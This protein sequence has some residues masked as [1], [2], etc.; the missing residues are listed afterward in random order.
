MRKKPVYIYHLIYELSKNSRS[1]KK[2]ISKKLKRSPQLVGY[3]IEKLKSTKQITGFTVQIDPSKFG[4]INVALFFVFTTFE[5]EK[6]EAILSYI[7]KSDYVVLAEEMGNGA[8]LFI[9]YSVPNLSFFNKKHMEFMG[10]FHKE[11]QVLGVYPII[12]KH[13]LSKKFLHPKSKERIHKIISGDRLLFKLQSNEKKIIEQLIRNPKATILDISKQTDLNVRTIMRI[14]KK[15]E[16]QQIIMGYSVILNRPMIGIKAC[17][18]LI[19]L[20]HMKPKDFNRIVSFAMTVPEITWVIKIL[21]R[22]S[23]LIQIE[24]LKEYKTVV[25][26]LRNQF[27]FHDY[28]VFEM[29]RTIKSTYLP[30]TLVHRVMW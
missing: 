11:I 12:V 4:L 29:A 23:F 22:Y 18:V 8:D 15:L 10:K 3:S 1:N 9:E 27:K 19:N 13:N 21:G 17:M 16:Q 14:K 20:E 5:K 30:P 25:D 6:R 24:T 26:L 7:N 28:K 2:T